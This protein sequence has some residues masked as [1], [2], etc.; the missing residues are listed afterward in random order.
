MVCPKRKP[1]LNY[2]ER[3]MCVFVCVVCVVM[4]V[5]MCGNVSLHVWVCDGVPCACVRVSLF[6]D[7]AYMMLY[8]IIFVFFSFL[9]RLFFIIMHP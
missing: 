8:E 6:L 9:L 3:W 7:V 1:S 4:C 2:V 5:C